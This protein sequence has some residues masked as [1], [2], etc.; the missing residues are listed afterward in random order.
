MNEDKGQSNEPDNTQQSSSP[1]KVCSEKCASLA[2]VGYGLIPVAVILAVIAL[3]PFVNKESSVTWGFWGKITLV[4]L[5]LSIFSYWA[6]NWKLDSGEAYVIR[7][8]SLD[9]ALVHRVIP[10]VQTTAVLVASLTLGQQRIH[11]TVTGFYLLL[12]ICLDRI[13]MKEANCKEKGEEARQ[14]LERI[15]LPVF[16][17]YS[18]TFLI[19]LAAKKDEGFVFMAGVMGSQAIAAGVAVWVDLYS[20][21]KCNV[22]KFYGVLVLCIVAGGIVGIVHYYPTILAVFS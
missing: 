3:D 13:L 5:L 1:T 22:E 19:S 18:I 17:S 20:Q 8:S 14:Y 21:R 6:L 10:F 7:S 9:A 4:A 11:S 12:F 2:A 15:D 16:I